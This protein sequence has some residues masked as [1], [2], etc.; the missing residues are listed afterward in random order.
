M[1]LNYSTKVANIF[2][3]IILLMFS[4]STQV[5]A[6]NI[7]MT[8]GGNSTVCSG[9]FY[10]PGGTGNYSVGDNTYIHTICSD[11]PG[12]FLLVDFSSFEVSLSIATI[13]SPNANDK[14]E[15]FDGP[16]TSSPK[17]GTY[18]GSELQGKTMIGQNGCL[19]FRFTT[20]HKYSGGGFCLGSK[21]N[22]GAPGW[23]ANISC[24]DEIPPTGENCVQA[25]PF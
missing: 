1:L 14:L 2:V 3:S 7:N 17:I 10:D 22:P 4:F 5:N 24:V 18:I 20:I 9:T 21:T 12:D 25:Y 6:Q 13:C 16:N 8:N 15:V 23:V 11:N 19:T